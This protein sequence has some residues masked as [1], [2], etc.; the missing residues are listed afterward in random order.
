M[1]CLLASPRQITRISRHHLHMGQLFS[2][3]A[4]HQH[5]DFCALVTARLN[6]NLEQDVDFCPGSI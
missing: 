6:V 2:A 1:P 3:H 4:Q 5:L